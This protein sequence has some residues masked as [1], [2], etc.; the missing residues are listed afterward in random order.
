MN[1]TSHE[2]IIPNLKTIKPYGVL[3]PLQ[4]QELRAF[5]GSVLQRYPPQGVNHPPLQE[6]HSPHKKSVIR[7]PTTSSGLGVCEASHACCRVDT[8]TGGLFI[9]KAMTK[10]TEPHPLRGVAVA[11]PTFDC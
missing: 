9:R 8:V 1:T 6:V 7:E 2:Q 5:D 3:S 10:S 4:R 11:K